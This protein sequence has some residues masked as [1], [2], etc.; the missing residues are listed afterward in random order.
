MCHADDVGNLTCDTGPSGGSGGAGGNSGGGWTCTIAS[1]GG[2]QCTN[3]NCT[4]QPSG[5]FGCSNG[6]S[7]TLPGPTP[8]GGWTC[9]PDDASGHEECDS[10]PPSGSGGSSGSTGSGGSS[11]AGGSGG[12]TGASCPTGGAQ[13]WCDGQTFCSWGK[14]TCESD[15]AGGYR[16]GTCVEGNPNNPPNPAPNTACSCYYPFSYAPQCCETQNCI[17]QGE[18]QV[19]CGTVNG[20][21]LCAPCG[22]DNNCAAGGLC[23]RKLVYQSD[24]ASGR[25]IGTVQQ[26]CSHSCNSPAD[27]GSGYNC[28]Q[29]SGSPTKFCVPS[30]GTCVP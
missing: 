5:E 25:T 21:G 9:H 24:P 11:G 23:V 1:N 6:S 19:P 3:P 29:P 30:S 2:Q 12:S 28:I 8:P 27:C 15:G 10:P 20:G 26:F 18:R 17:V 13:R 4:Q 16:W 14:Q 22:D 7:P